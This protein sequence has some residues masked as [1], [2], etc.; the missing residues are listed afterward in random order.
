MEARA[1]R[2]GAQRSSDEAKREFGRVCASTGAGPNHIAGM[3]FW[4]LAFLILAVISGI[5]GFTSL[6]GTAADV[7]RVLFVVF[8][9]L[10]VVSAVSRRTKRG[11]TP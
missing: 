1:Y 5:F 3:F 8:L 7:A 2:P 11:K 9:V 6:A 4:T 10:L